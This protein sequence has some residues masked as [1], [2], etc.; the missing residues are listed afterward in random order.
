MHEKDV[1]VELERLRSDREGLLETIAAQSAELVG[2]YRDIDHLKRTIELMGTNALPKHE[3]SKEWL[4]MLRTK[5]L[6]I[7]RLNGMVADLRALVI[8]AMVLA[9]DNEDFATWKFQARRK[10]DELGLNSEGL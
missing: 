5:E 8:L 1:E 7:D 4:D 10:L 3:N 2:A 6:S 9:R